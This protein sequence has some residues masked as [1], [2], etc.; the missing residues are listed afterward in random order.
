MDRLRRH[1]RAVDEMAVATE[2]QQASQYRQSTEK[3]YQQDLRI[4][5]SEWLRP[6]NVREVHR[7]HLGERLIG[8]CEWIQD[9]AAYVAWNNPSPKTPEEHQV[10]LICGQPGCGKS[11]LASAMLER[12]ESQAK[13]VLYFPFSNGNSARRYVKDL[14]HSLVWQALDALDD[15]GCWD[16]IHGL[17]SKGPVLT[18]ALWDALASI[19]SHDQ[20]PWTLILDGVDECLEL[21]E[22][23]RV[24]IPG[25][26]R[27]NGKLQAAILGRPQILQHRRAL[28]ITAFIEITPKMVKRDIKFFIS[29]R[30]NDA[31]LLRDHVSKDL[32]I[33]TLQK[34]AEGMFLWARLVIQDLQKS[35]SAAEV[36]QRLGACLRV[37]STPIGR[38][39]TICTIL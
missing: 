28:G 23:L 32:V 3:I 20:R 39:L 6:S 31:P 15:K 1:A 30:V 35:S 37:S 36:H 22:L 10:L 33:R 21:D 19:L 4:R 18:S 24:R 7:R 5:C 14:A 9:Q 38:Y 16:T 12:A 26:L 17:M 13:N 2:L 11:I 25:L 34:Q 27:S 8:T 29:E